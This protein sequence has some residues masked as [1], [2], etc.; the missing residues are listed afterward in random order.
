MK[1]KSKRRDSHNIGQ[2]ETEGRK[3]SNT[4]TY[5]TCSKA[6]KSEKRALKNN[7]GNKNKRNKCLFLNYPSMLHFTCLLGRETAA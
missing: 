3:T 1:R 6:E 2:G 5:A 7:N 4:K